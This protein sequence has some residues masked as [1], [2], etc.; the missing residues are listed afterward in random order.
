MG[1]SERLG[2]WSI[3]IRAL[4]RCVFLGA[5]P[6]VSCQGKLLSPFECEYLAQK[7]T[8]VTSVEQ[9]RNPRLRREVQE[10]TQR[11]LLTPYDREFVRCLEVLGRLDACEQD[12][13]RRVGS[14]SR[15]LP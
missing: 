10:R 8:G 13:L 3:G 12:L 2:F 5:L 1:S 14:P 15:L 11:C 4:A 9:L 7:M 6:L